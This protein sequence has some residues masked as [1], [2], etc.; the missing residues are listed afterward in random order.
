[1]RVEDREAP[2]RV[3][4]LDGERIHLIERGEGPPVVLLHGF[5]G[6]TFS[7]RSVMEPLAGGHQVVAIDFPG[8]GYSSRDATLPLGHDDQADRVARVMDSLGLEHAVVVGHSMGGGIA[9]RLAIRHPGKVTALVLIS[10]V[11]ASDRA[12]WERGQQRSRGLVRAGLIA[13]RMPWLVKGAIGRGLRGMVFDP[14]FVTREVVD[15][16][17]GPLLFK[18][19][20]KCLEA[21]FEAVVGEQ[22]ADL[23]QISVPTLVL[24]GEVDT[25]VPIATGERLAAT[26]ARARH[27]VLRKVGHLGA[28]EQPAA[29]LGA[30]EAFE[31]ELAPAA[32]G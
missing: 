15:G 6:S 5:G 9:Q 20:A 10:S 7:W 12:R 16:Y 21:M 13:A 3:L 19:T 14:A 26:I 18:G 28:E 11:D 1:M 32:A 2:G 24:S 8:F 31:Q 25:V 29:F 17:A 23:S 4:D 22:P 27:E 30:L